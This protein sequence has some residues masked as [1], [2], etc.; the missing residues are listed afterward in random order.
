LRTKTKRRLS[1]LL[2]LTFLLTMGLA[3]SGQAATETI[4]IFQVG[5]PV[6]TVDGKARE[7][8]VVPRIDPQ[9]GR[10][11]LPL[12]Y[13]AEALNA[14]VYWNAEGGQITIVH[15]ETQ[16]VLE[17][18]VGEAAMRTA[19]SAD[20][21]EDQRL[22][23]APMVDPSGRTMLP[24][25]AVAEALY[26]KISY[27][28]AT[29]KITIVRPATRPASLEP[30]PDSVDFGSVLPMDE[31]NMDR[32][33][34]NVRP[35]T[36]TNRG[37]GPLFIDS[38]GT[39]G[40]VFNLCRREYAPFVLK[41]GEA[42]DIL[43]CA[44]TIRPGQ[45]SG[46]L[47]VKS[48]VQ[49]STDLVVSRIRLII[50]VLGCSVTIDGGGQRPNTA[51]SGTAP[52]PAAGV[53]RPVVNNGQLI[54]L[55]ANV[56]GSFGPYTYQW[57]VGGNH[58]KEYQ[59]LTAAAWSTTAM[60][61]ADYQN[62]TIDY[63]WKQVG[64]HVV[65]VKVTNSLGLTCSATSNWTAEVNNTSIDRQ[66]EDFYTW[67]HNSRVLRE[68]YTWHVA[69]PY[70]PCAAAGLPFQ[71]FHKAYLGR[72]NS[73]RATFGYPGL[74]AWL[75]NTPLPGGVPNQHL[76]RAGV[77]NPAVH[78]V[79]TYLTAVGGALASPCF[80]ARKKADFPSANAYWIEA[81]G[82]FHNSIHGAIGGFAGDMGSFA[83][84]PKDPIFWRWHKFLD[85]LWP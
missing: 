18:A 34:D 47:L 52:L 59:E 81:E 2:I 28:P 62:P 37:Q 5:S 30:A 58:V 53:D 6:Y 7:M 40:G 84:A 38:V 41:P 56:T 14:A 16:R 79:P 12:R 27:D 29:R 1:A 33:P 25:R 83:R 74:A 80:G 65:S 8:D 50:L 24:I 75:P 9:S 49:I 85:S 68:H 15:N 46:Q 21:Y 76:S 3:K 57:T 19:D 73:W 69:N 4:I 39:E 60:A 82:P 66:A 70:S 63:Y 67:N 42:R 22:E 32:H 61:A 72:F 35:V 71:T 11:L 43:V 48:H 55:M 17:L 31:Q 45:F 78:A 54:H 26:G 36:I 10:T 23:Q 77:Y 20:R 64:N 13:A 44:E 51:T